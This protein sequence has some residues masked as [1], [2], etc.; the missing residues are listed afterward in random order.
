MSK[1]KTRPVA[2]PKTRIKADSAARIKTAV[3]ISP[4]A[5]KKLGACTIEEGM[6]QSEVI[7]FLIMRTLG[8]YYVTVQGGHG[9]HDLAGRLSGA[10]PVTNED[11]LENDGHVNLNASEAA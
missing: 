4:E 10:N 3:C 5:F 11:R 7:E 1:S 9:I 6:T 2:K 8:P